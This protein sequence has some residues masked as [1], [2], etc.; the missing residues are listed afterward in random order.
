MGVA[1]LSEK[2]KCSCSVTLRPQV[3]MPFLMFSSFFL[4]KIVG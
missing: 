2:M 3:V 1:L 4:Q